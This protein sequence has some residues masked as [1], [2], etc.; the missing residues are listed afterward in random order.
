MKKLTAIILLISICTLILAGCNTNAPPKA[1]YKNDRYI[2]QLGPSA[3]GKNIIVKF[4]VIEKT[5]VPACPD[6]LCEHKNG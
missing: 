1:E 4:D 6:P 3:N 2:Y 5:A